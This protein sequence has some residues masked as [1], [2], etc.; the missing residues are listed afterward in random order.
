MRIRNARHVRLLIPSLGLELDPGEERRI[1]DATQ[2][3][4]GLERVEAAPTAAA[5]KPRKKT[6]SR[7]PEAAP[8]ESQEQ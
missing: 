7:Q 6:T 2:I 5:A 1:P 8:A 4:D 3:P